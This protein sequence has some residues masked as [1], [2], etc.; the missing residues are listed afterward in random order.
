MEILARE[1]LAMN[2]ND[3]YLCSWYDWSLWLQHIYTAR[4][5]RQEDHELLMEMF[6]STWTRFYNWNRGDN[7][8]I[9]PQDFFR[10]SY[11]TDKPT[12]TEPKEEDKLALVEKIKRMESKSKWKKRG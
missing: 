2:S 6:R 3:F 9:S 1:E 4:R 7:P 12:D 11:D 10:L 5:R 8:A